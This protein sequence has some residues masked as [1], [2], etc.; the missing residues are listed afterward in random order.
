MFSNFLNKLHII[1]WII[2]V[3][4]RIYKSFILNIFFKFP[5]HLLKKEH[6]LHLLTPLVTKQKEIKCPSES[7]ESL[8][9]RWKVFIFSSVYRIIDPGTSSVVASSCC[10]VE[11]LL[12]IFWAV[13]TGFSCFLD[14]AGERGFYAFL[15][16]CGSFQNGEKPFGSLWKT[17]LFVFGSSK[18]DNGFENKTENF[19][20]IWR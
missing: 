6:N 3:F 20:T 7:T 17:L 9:S 4:H 15:N 10:L 12:A 11:L 5:N 13:F 14:V 18:G 19:F 16:N 2:V 1:L 8:T